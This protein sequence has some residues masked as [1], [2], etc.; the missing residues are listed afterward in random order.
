MSPAPKSR[1][2]VRCCGNTASRGVL[3][4]KCFL[5]L[6]SGE[7]DTTSSAW[8]VTEMVF[9]EQQNETAMGVVHHLH[10]RVDELSD[11]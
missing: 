2:I 1:C 11:D 4:R 8:F 10:S 7:I 9:M 3:C 5:I 6:G